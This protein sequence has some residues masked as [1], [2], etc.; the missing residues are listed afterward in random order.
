MEENKTG[1]GVINQIFKENAKVLSVEEAKQTGI[2]PEHIEEAVKYIRQDRARRGYFDRVWEELNQ[3]I[4]M[5]GDLSEEDK[6]E[7]F[8][9]IT[10]F[11]Q[12]MKDKYDNEIKEDE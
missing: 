9:D 1:T 4:G 11:V 3:I 5:L 6:E 12:R 10:G 7:A 2:T 8:N